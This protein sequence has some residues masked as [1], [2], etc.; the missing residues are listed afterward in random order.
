MTPLIEIC[1]LHVER[2]DKTVLTIDELA[3][4]KG[5]VLAVV[6]PNG[7]G[8]STLLLTLARL[9]RPKHGEILFGG[10]RVSAESDTAY[11]R[12]IALVLQDPL[13]F[14]I[15]VFDNISSGLR[16]RGVEKSKIRPRVELWLERLG[17][18]ELRNRRATE[19]SGG[20]AQ[21]VSL[22]R[23]LVLEPELL[24]LDEPFSALDPP[25]HKR[26]LAE[27]ATLLTE[28][29]TTTVFITHDL[30]E[31]LNLGQHMAVILGGNLRQVGS[32]DEILHASSDPEIVAFIKQ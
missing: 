3:I 5:D 20:E 32:P 2:G 19:V 13:L 4:K 6:G 27:L 28:T 22:A 31:A 10:K 17:I 7:A 30:D 9:L 24:L 29:L 26:L 11:R 1:D 18:S 8:K 23:A 14:D 25:T 16:F 12:R 21:R 15:S